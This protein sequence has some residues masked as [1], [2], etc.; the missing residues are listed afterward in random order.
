MVPL[1]FANISLTSLKV[2]TKIAKTGTSARHITDRA[3]LETLASKNDK[4]WG[5]GF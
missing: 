3:V 5:G 1:K 2:R 4:T